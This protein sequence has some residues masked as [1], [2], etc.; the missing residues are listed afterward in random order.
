MVQKCECKES[1]E[2]S[3]Y[4]PTSDLENMQHQFFPVVVFLGL[5]CSNLHQRYKALHG[6][7]QDTAP[8]LKSLLSN[9][10]LDKA[11][12][13][14]EGKEHK[15]NRHQTMPYASWDLNRMALS[16]L[17]VLLKFNSL[18][19]ERPDCS[20]TINNLSTFFVA[21]IAV[22]ETDEIWMLWINI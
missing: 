13:M 11:S 5:G 3:F 14:E 9:W 12:E 6:I 15:S 1:H 17:K 2:K 10:K 20:S 8:A 16:H 18:N 19:A 22:S 7:T 21:V 4:F